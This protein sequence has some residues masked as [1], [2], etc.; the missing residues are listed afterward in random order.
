MMTTGPGPT[1]TRRRLRAELRRLRL[2][3][4]LSVED[5]TNE[6]EWSMSKLIRIEGGQVGISVSD[7]NALLK[8]YDVADMAQLEKLRTL[9]R[10]SRQRTWWSAYQRFLS[11]SY[12]E[13]I[14]AESDATR[15]RHYHPTMVPGL[16]QTRGYAE[17]IIVATALESVPDDVVKARFEIRQQRQQHVLERAKPPA[18]TVILDEA[19]LRRPVGGPDVMREQLDHL[20]R[21]AKRES[22]NL[23]VLPFSAGPH[24]GLGGAF[25]LLEYEGSLNEDV[26]C[27]ETA[28]GNFVFNEQRELIEQ[29]GRVADHLE[30]VGLAEPAAIRFLQQVR[31]AL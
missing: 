9:A 5:V 23:V 11:P 18:F 21:M 6:V 20:I 26:L 17:A 29:Y 28:S 15:I 27:L 16:L 22:V 14:G 10:A 3:K 31:K 25:S 8:I 13:F 1:T 19:V 12:Q 4:G 7:L 2:G 30:Q 24:P